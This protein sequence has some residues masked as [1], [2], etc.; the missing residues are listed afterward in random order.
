MKEWSLE[1][2][3]FDKNIIKWDVLKEK[4]NEILIKYENFINNEYEIL[5]NQQKYDEIDENLYKPIEEIISIWFP[6]AL[7]K[8]YENYNDIDLVVNNILVKSMKY[9]K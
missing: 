8:K 1:N 6:Y 2:K 5:Y 7:N 3:L 4:S 9:Y